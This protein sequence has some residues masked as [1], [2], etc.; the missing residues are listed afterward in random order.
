MPRDGPAA[1][2]QR[3]QENAYAHD[4]KPVCRVR[5]RRPLN[6]TRAL[7]GHAAKQL[8][9]HAVK[10]SPKPKTGPRQNPRAQPGPPEP[11]VRPAP[12]EQ[13][14][15]P[16]RLDPRRAARSRSQTWGSTSARPRRRIR[17]CSASSVSSPARSRRL[18]RVDGE[19]FI[20]ERREPH[21][22]GR[23]LTRDSTG[24]A[25]LRDPPL[26]AADAGPNPD[27][28]RPSHHA[29]QKRENPALSRVSLQCG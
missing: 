13:Q 21:G 19:R 11:Q 10:K 1:L 16:G 28:G 6:L 22:V 29:P 27:G 2:G 3:F 8:A 5:R 12:Q 25:G 9:T 23:K 17:R 14:E 26:P 15:Q 24:E 18:H 20:R 7:T 4:V